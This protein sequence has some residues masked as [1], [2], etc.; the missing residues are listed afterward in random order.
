MGYRQKYLKYKIKYLSLKGG[1]SDTQH[2]NGL[3]SLIPESQASQ[4]VK[5]FTVEGH[6]VQCTYNAYAA[7]TLLQDVLQ[8]ERLLIDY[9]D[10]PNPNLGDPLPYTLWHSILTTGLT[11]FKSCD[12]QTR[13]DPNEVCSQI[14]E[15]DCYMLHSTTGIHEEDFKKKLDQHKFIM[16]NNS[17]ETILWYKLND[18][19]QLVID[20]HKKEGLFKITNKND[21]VKSIYPTGHVVT[22]PMIYPSLLRYET[23][24]DTGA[25]SSSSPSTT[26]ACGVCTFINKIHATNCEMCDTHI[27][28]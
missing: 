1:S 23:V 10:N 14:L 24:S 7:I 15:P 26:N 2:D 25:A 8:N 6:S 20:T 4:Y 19:H 28:G 16:I 21:W 17:G 18:K 22:V 12:E 27:Q 5:E 11:M 13:T 3:S 9:L